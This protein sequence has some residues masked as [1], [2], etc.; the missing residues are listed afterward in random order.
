MEMDVVVLV[1]FFEVNG[2][3]DLKVGDVANSWVV[4]SFVVLALV[5]VSSL[6]R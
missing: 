3:F 2:N 1:S 4:I 6:V 5:V